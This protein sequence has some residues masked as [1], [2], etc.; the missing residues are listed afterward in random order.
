MSPR[1]LAM[2]PSA[3]VFGIDPGL[4]RCGWAVISSGLK[5]QLIA[6]G[7]LI[8]PPGQPDSQRLA[9]LYRRLGELLKKYRPALVAVEKLYLTKNVSSAMAVGQARGIALLAAAETGLPI[10]EFSPTTVKQSVTGDG[11]ADKRQLQSMVMRLLSIDRAP[12][13]DDTIDALAIALCAAPSRVLP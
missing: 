13:Y 5:P 10:R 4:A 2:K 1:S 3:R 12:R 11:R 7:C 8:T 9:T 6:A